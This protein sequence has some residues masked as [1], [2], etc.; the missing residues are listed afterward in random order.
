MLLDA[1][2]APLALVKE[3]IFQQQAFLTDLTNIV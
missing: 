2:W 1:V 3:V